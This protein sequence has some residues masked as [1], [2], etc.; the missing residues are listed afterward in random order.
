[1]T[2]RREKCRGKIVLS[3]FESGKQVLC[4]VSKTE[5]INESMRARNTVLCLCAV[6]AR[7]GAHRQSRGAFFNWKL[8]FRESL[9]DV[10]TLI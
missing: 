4:R 8:E 7:P 9:S 10:V 2:K 3:V 6:I 1:M 5:R